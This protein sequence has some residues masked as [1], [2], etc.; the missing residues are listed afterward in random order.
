M[1]TGASSPTDPSAPRAAEVRSLYDREQ[2]AM[3]RLASVLVSSRETAED[4]VQDAFS[5]VEQRWDS[6]D[7]PGAYLRTTVVNG[8]RAVLRRREAEQR[9]L[10]GSLPR[11]E[12]PPPEHLIEL[13]D[14]LDRLGERQRV[15]IVLRFF[16]DLPFVDVARSM[17]C[18]PSTA[19]SL[20]RRGLASLR[21]ELQED[22]T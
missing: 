15:A 17:E 13:L 20:V 14:V 18:R 9:N 21:Q 8:C 11:V 5:A 3:L 2:L 22:S 10:T 1:S 19:R 4:V 16:A 7:S 6:I 12:P